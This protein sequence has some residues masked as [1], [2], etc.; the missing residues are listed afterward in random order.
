MVVFSLLIL[1]ARPVALSGLLLCPRGYLLE[2]V[3]F[4]VSKVIG[5]ESVILLLGPLVGPLRPIVGAH[6]LHVAPLK[7]CSASPRSLRTRAGFLSSGGRLTPLR[8]KLLYMLRR[9]A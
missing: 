4:L 2:L 5:I 7:P 6:V 9:F 3:V 1:V 8:F